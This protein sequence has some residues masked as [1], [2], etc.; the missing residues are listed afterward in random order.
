MNPPLPDALTIVGVT[1]FCIVMATA[2]YYRKIFNFSGSVT[3][4]VVGMAIGIF[5][6][7]LWLL[8]LLV[9]LISSFGATKYRFEWKKSEGFQEGTRGERTWRNVAANGAVPALIALLSFIA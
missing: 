7:I 6:D 1:T 9:F 8:L 4:F 2:S 3:A 5:G